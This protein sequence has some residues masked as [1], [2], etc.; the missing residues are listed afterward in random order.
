E[1][2]RSGRVRRYVG[3]TLVHDPTR[4]LVPR[5]IRPILRVLGAADFLI[6]TPLGDGDGARPSGPR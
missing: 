6:L 4:R 2:V 1:A 3:P 5:A